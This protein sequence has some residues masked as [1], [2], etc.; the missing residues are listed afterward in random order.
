MES[1]QNVLWKNDVYEVG[2]KTYYYVF[3]KDHYIQRH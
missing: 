1:I 2:E 3:D